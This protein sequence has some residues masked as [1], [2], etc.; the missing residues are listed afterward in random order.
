MEVS[1]LFSFSSLAQF[2]DAVSI[3][4]TFI[5]LSCSP[6]IRAGNLYHNLLMLAAVDVLL[7]IYED[8]DSHNLQVTQQ[9]QSVLHLPKHGTHYPPDFYF[10]RYSFSHSWCRLPH[11]SNAEGN[12]M[13]NTMELSVLLTDGVL[14]HCNFYVVYSLIKMGELI[15]SN[16]YLH[17]SL[18]R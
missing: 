9:L 2:I 13:N 3:S 4:F 18:P 16:K 15:L 6:C 7:H 11:P 5:Y 1:L 12:Q 8:L 10:M 17:R 14:Q